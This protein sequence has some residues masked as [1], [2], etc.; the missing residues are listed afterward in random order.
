MEKK[1]KALEMYLSNF[2][3][4]MK[5]NVMLDKDLSE[6]IGLTFYDFDIKVFEEDPNES[7][8]VG[9]IRIIKAD[10]SE[11]S[12]YVV[13]DSASNTECFLNLTDE[14][15]VLEKVEEIAFKTHYPCD[16][17]KMY[18]LD[19]IVVEKAYRGTGL[20]REAL[21]K[22][23]DILNLDD[24]VIYLKLFPLQFENI[25]EKF[26]DAEFEVAQKKLKKH[27]LKWGFKDLIKNEGG[28]FMYGLT[29]LTTFLPEKKEK[30]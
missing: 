22:A 6:H 12:P 30:R 26:V 28:H 9:M 2:G 8:S 16:Y 7:N 19:R 5:I 27:Y 29:G 15:G 18:I 17:G 4:E 1:R 10:F 23:L 3:I 21:K 24:H 25:N 11:N 20:A 13:L 14:D